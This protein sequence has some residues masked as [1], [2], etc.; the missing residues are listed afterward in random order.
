MTWSF[1][2][3]LIPSASRIFDGMT[4][5]YFDDM[6]IVLIRFS[7]RSRYC[8]ATYHDPAHPGTGTGHEFEEERRAVRGIADQRSGGP[9]CAH[10]ALI[11]QRYP[12]SRRKTMPQI[13]PSTFRLLADLRER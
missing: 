10:I 9:R 6:V 8:K 3:G 5:W 12:D 2:P 7:D 1:S 13:A 11:L 4:I